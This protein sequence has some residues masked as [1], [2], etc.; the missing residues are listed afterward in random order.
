[1]ILTLKVEHDVTFL[2]LTGHNLLSYETVSDAGTHTILFCS[3]TNN[4]LFI[5]A[6]QLQIED[7]T[8]EH[9]I[10]PLEPLDTHTLGG[11]HE[12]LGS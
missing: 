12:I 5:S 2:G 9:N 7:T 8:V 6:I 10:M 4:N 3:Y 1:M 11:E